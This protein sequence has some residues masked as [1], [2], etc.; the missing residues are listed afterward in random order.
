PERPGP[1]VIT[2]VTVN[3]IYISWSEAAGIADLYE[4]TYIPDN[5]IDNSPTYVAGTEYTLTG[6]TPVTEYSIAI[7]TTAGQLL[8]EAR[9]TNVYTIPTPPQSITVDQDDIGPT[10]A[11]VSWQPSTGDVD[12]YVITYSP[13][14]TASG[15]WISASPLETSKDIVGLV[16]EPTY[17]FTIMAYS[18]GLQSAPVTSMAV[19]L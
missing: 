2:S 9:Q 13:Y 7:K 4:I 11:R 19:N 17:T 1:I 10:Y 16:N 5:G 15:P 8:S 12:E 18:G 14:I 3:R 6:L